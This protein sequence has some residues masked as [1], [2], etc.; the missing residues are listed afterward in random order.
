MRA[1]NSH[2]AAIAGGSVL[3]GLDLSSTTDFTAMA[4]LFPDDEDASYDV[5]VFF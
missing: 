3:F 4:L 2:S 5:L 1:S